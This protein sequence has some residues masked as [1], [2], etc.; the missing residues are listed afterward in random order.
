[1]DNDLSLGVCYAVGDVLRKSREMKMKLKFFKLIKYIA[2]WIAVVFFCFAL[3]VGY[4]MITDYHP[5]DLLSIETHNNPKNA[6]EKASDIN[7][8]TWNIGYAGLDQTQDF[9]MDGGKK[10]KPDSIDRVKSN[11]EELTQLIKLQ[12]ADVLMLQEVD[13]NS[14]RTYEVDELKYLTSHLDT[15]GNSFAYNYK[16]KYVPVPFPPLGKIEA[17]QVT[18]TAFESVESLR[19]ALP[20]Q[21]AWP[22]SLVMLDRCA[23]VNYIKIKGSDEKLVIIN[24]HLSAYDDGSIREQQMAYVRAFIKAEYEKGNYVVLGGDFN[25]TFD[26]IPDSRFPLFQ[27][28]KFYKPYKIPK[29]WLLEGWSW[30]VGTNAPTYRLLN[31]PYEEGQTQEGIIDGFLLSPNVELRKAF[32]LDEGFKSS[33]HNPVRLI[34]HLK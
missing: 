25:Q 31:A 22:K 9:F 33:D 1:M 14:A 20:G 28:G 34:I 2:I 18:L 3:F 19:L 13:V 26:F 11:L 29:E 12:N 4:L 17:G 16:V 8:M 24:V 5:Q 10:S 30:G 21:Y 32:V 15:F 23:L 7:V 6:V 27:D